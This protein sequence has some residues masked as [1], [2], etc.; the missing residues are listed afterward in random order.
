MEGQMYNECMT[1]EQYNQ[2]QEQIN[3][4]NQYNNWVEQQFHPSVY[5]PGKRCNKCREFKP[6]TEYHFLS[7]SKDGYNNKCKI[8]R[9]VEAKEYRQTPG[10][11]ENIIKYINKP[12]VIEARKENIYRIDIRKQININ[13]I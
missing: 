1:W 12:E 5:T 11:T 9:N 8:C 13:N 4:Y 6:Y 2:L 3:W 10:Y 7:S